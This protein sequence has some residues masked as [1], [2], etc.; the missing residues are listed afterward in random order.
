MHCVLVLIKTHT[1]RQF[2]LCVC[3]CKRECTK[4]GVWR[5]LTVLILHSFITCVLFNNTPSGVSSLFRKSHNDAKTIRA[6]RAISGYFNRLFSSSQV[7]LFIACL[8]SHQ[9]I[10]VIFWRT[11]LLGNCCVNQH[12]QVYK[13]SFY[14]SMARYGSLNI[15]F[16]L[17]V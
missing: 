8:F 6:K 13:H 16:F 5:I 4:N 3:V 12:F 7:Y 10:H 9:N 2:A 1:H 14:S 11:Q 17:H 15:N